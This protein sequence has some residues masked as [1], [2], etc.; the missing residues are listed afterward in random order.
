MQ[1]MIRNELNK[2]SVIMYCRQSFKKVLDNIKYN[3]YLIRHMVNI[4]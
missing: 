4:K 2:L 1:Q 3:K